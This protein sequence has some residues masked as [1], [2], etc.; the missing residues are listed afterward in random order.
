MEMLKTGP[1][2]A[3]MCIVYQINIVIFQRSKTGTGICIC[4][5]IFFDWCNSLQDRLKCENSGELHRRR[6]TLVSNNEKINK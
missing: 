3:N 6:F 2:I 1:V 5:Y 4:I